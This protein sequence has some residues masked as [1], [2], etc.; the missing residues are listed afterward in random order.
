MIHLACILYF[1]YKGENLIH[2]KISN[3]RAGST[4][5]VASKI[6]EQLGRI[7]CLELIPQY[8]YPEAYKCVME[9]AEIEK[10]EKKH[11]SYQNLDI[12]FDKYDTIFLGYPNW[13]G[14]IPRIVASFLED[15]SLK[16]IN[17]YPFCTHEGSGLGNSIN[18]I[19]EICPKAQIFPGLSIRGT[20]ADKSDTAIKNWLR[21]YYSNR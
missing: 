19:R 16:N 10:E 1:S 12:H 21:Q 5:R 6:S 18:E 11:V 13:C 15:N 17:I 9:I 20:N 7:S 4:A 2:G 3:N 8:P 14:T